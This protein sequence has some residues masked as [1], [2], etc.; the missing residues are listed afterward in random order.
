MWVVEEK[1]TGKFAGGVGFS[2]HK[3]DIHPPLMEMPELGWLLA[4]NFHGKGYAT[5]AASAAAAWGD[6]RFGKQPMVCIVHEENVRSIRVAE[7]CGFRESARSS[8]K[9]KATIVFTRQPYK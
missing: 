7:K 5:E 3:R 2:N 4:S 9:G 1:A 8:Y 6:K